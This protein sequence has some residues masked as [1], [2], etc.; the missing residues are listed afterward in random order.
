MADRLSASAGATAATLLSC[1]PQLTQAVE[2]LEAAF[3]LGQHLV[4]SSVA[5]QAEKGWPEAQR[6]AFRKTLADSDTMAVILVLLT[7]HLKGAPGQSKSDLAR[8]LYQ[9][10]SPREL[11]AARWRVGKMVMRL[12]AYN[13]VDLTPREKHGLA[14]NVSASKTLI[15]LFKTD[16]APRLVTAAR[17][18]LRRKEK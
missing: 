18:T 8:A 1:T 12:Q 10:D 2:L 16:L 7:A 14:D 17:Q 3:T 9:T 11:N 13:L 4:D 15:E 6:L 5:Q